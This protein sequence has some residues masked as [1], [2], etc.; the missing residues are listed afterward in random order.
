MRRSGRI[1]NKDRWVGGEVMR[2]V[3]QVE[4]KEVYRRWYGRYAGL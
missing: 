2:L 3:S 4:E 1:L